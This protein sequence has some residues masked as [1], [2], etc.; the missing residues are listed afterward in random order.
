MGLVLY[1][2]R[3]ERSMGTYGEARPA[4]VH[5]DRR[6]LV[7]AA[8][9]GLLGGW[10]VYNVIVIYWPVQAVQMGV[11]ETVRGMVEFAFATAQALSA[12]ALV[13]VKGW[14]HKPL[15]LAGLG[16]LAIVGLGFF[17]SVTAPLLL[18]LGGLLYG[19]Y[20]GGMWTH[21]AYHSMLE[22]EKAVQ[23]VALNETFVG[24]CF[25]IASPVS[26]LLHRPGAPFGASYWRLAAVLAVALLVQLGVAY[27]LLRRERVAAEA[28]G[29]T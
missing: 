16:G 13:Y 17:G 7:V 24:I 21:M 14:H 12:L 26:R 15:W 23:R 29:L 27:S 8:W 1:S 10:T 2:F 3:P 19:I 28:A 20:L 6:S 25:L 11:S 5:S 4:P 9:V 22:E 18:A